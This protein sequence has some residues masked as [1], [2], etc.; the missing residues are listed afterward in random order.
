MLS[1]NLCI[2]AFKEV[3]K[4]DAVVWQGRCAGWIAG[5]LSVFL[6]LTP[7]SA[8]RQAT[9][10]SRSWVC[11]VLIPDLPRPYIASHNMSC[12]YLHTN[13]H[14]HAYIRLDF[15]TLTSVMALSKLLRASLTLDFCTLSSTSCWAGNESGEGQRPHGG[16]LSWLR[17]RKYASRGR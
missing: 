17:Y 9:A 15:C 3:L 1:E 6:T 10:A 8:S 11:S 13:A 7:L 14:G 5:G 16:H 12:R 2:E 4:W